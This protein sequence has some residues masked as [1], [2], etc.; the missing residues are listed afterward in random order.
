M[1]DM[2]DAELKSLRKNYNMER[3]PIELQEKVKV[4]VTMRF[5]RSFGS[6][7]RTNK[8][9]GHW[10]KYYCRFDIEDLFKKAEAAFKTLAIF[11]PKE[12]AEELG[13]HIA[14]L[15]ERMEVQIMMYNVHDCYL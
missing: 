9:I 1:L 12:K 15:S 3:A 13:A 11:A 4:A 2:A 14:N 10:T 6:F 5:V 7:Y 8:E